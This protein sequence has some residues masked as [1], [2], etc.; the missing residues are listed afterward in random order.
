MIDRE[1]RQTKKEEFIIE[2]DREERD[3]DRETG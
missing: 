1:E 3:I 2:R